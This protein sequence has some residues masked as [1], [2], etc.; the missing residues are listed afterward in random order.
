M[1]DHTLN[2]FVKD[3][4]NQYTQFW[5]QQ[6]NSS[7]KLSFYSTFKEHY[8]LEEYLN[9]IRDH[10]QRRQFSKFR[11]SKHKLEIEFGRYR[12]VPREERICKNCDQ[13]VVEDEFHF[14]FECKKYKNLRNDAQNILKEY[15]E[16]NISTGT[17]LKKELITKIMSLHDPVITNLF[18]DHISK[19]FHIRDKGP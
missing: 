1:Q 16:V 12:N 15:F 18:S 4:K 14:S 8:N 13:S 11:I 6:I 5:K 19:C 3:I 2:N 7:T 9:I 17:E 10:N